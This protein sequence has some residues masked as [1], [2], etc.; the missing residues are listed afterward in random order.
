[1]EE[2]QVD[3]NHSQESI[4]LQVSDDSV[5]A[6]LVE[7]LAILQQ[8]AVQLH[9]PLHV[10]RVLTVFGPILPLVMQWQRAFQKLMPTF[11][12]ADIPKCVFRIDFGNLLLSKSSRDICFQGSDVSLSLQPLT[13]PSSCI[14][15]QV[16][17]AKRPVARALCFDDIF[18]P[19]SESFEFS[20]IPEVTTKRGR[21][22][23]AVKVL[24]DTEVRRSARLSALRDGY[25]R[26]PS[27]A[28]Q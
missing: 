24:V 21:K 28:S 14:P 22:P 3:V 20:A 19:V 11:F 17:P 25:H 10:G 23:R 26:S 1:M 4:I 8:P 2:N 12:S 5:N 27:R 18:E 7:D 13:E 6:Q 15:H 9:P 16:S